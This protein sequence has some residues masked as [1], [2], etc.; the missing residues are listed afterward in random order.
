VPRRTSP[1]SPWQLEV[2]LANGT[3]EAQA[4]RQAFSESGL[5]C[6]SCHGDQAQGD[7]GPRLAGGRDVEEFRRVHGKLLFPPSMVSDR[8]FAAI[9]AYL[10]S[11]GAAG[12]R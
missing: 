12:E 2:A 11:L 4:G 1:S 5:G 3:S 6:A 9:D 7:R 10:R 8:D